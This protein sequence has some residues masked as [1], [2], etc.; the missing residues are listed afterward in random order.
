M[1]SGELSFEDIE[2]AVENKERM[3]IHAIEDSRKES[4]EDV[5]FRTGYVTDVFKIGSTKAVHMKP[6]T[7]LNISKEREIFFDD[8]YGGDTIS[9]ALE[10]DG[11]RIYSIAKKFDIHALKSKPLV[12]DVCGAETEFFKNYLK[13]AKE[14]YV[15]K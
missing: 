15:F 3:K 13:L 2:R 12:R 9:V 11:S 7:A 6:Y 1:E 4:S 8:D 14:L 5:L 10:A